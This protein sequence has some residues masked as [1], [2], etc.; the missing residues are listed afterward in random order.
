MNE[1]VVFGIGIII[2]IRDIFAIRSRG[3]RLSTNTATGGD[4]F[5]DG[6][7]IEKTFNEGQEAHGEDAFSWPVLQSRLEHCPLVMSRA[8]FGMSTASHDRNR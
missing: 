5:V 2:V 3:F 7:A 8:K 6:S 1:F 4:S